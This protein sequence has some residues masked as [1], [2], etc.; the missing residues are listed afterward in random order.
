MKLNNQQ[1]HLT[2]IEMLEAHPVLD[3]GCVLHTHFLNS[4][5]K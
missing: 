3:L 1:Q 5:S 4:F 2:L